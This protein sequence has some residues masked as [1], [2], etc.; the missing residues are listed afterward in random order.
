VVI[1]NQ[2]LVNRFWPGQNAI[3]RRIQFNRR[4]LTVV[5]VA[6]N[7]KYRRLTSDVAPLVLLP[8]AQR[9]QSEAILHVRAIGDPQALATA[10]EQT[11]HGLNANLPLYNVTTLR[12]NMKFGSVF[13]RIAVAIAGS[14]GALALL[15]AAIGIYG[16]VSYTARQRTHEIGIRIALGAGKAAIFAQVLRHGL[17]LTLAGLLAGVC[18]SLFLTR[19]L[20]SMLY[21]VGTTDVLTFATVA[22][23][24]CA[25]AIL[26]C[27]LP[28]RRAA[29]VDPMQALRTE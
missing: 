17:R 29:S 8:L 28:A 23:V 7:G 19:F 3:G 1:V 6:T 13:E 5:G 15:L 11:V 14:F 2:A 25:V 10:V 16:V 4:W 21:G 26:A 20:R 9:F 18:A 27:Y 12:E 24:L 22:A